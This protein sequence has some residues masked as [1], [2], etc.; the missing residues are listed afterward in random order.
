[1]KKIKLTKEEQQVFENIGLSTHG[2]LTL[3]R[4]VSKE[5]KSAWEKITKKYKI[6]STSNASIE[7]GYLTLPWEDGY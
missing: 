1:M 6:E 5:E 7:D 4:M 3:L 2:L